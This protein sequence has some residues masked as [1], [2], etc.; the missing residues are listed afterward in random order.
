[1]EECPSENKDQLRKREGEL[2]RE[3]KAGLNKLVAGR[4]SVE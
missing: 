3:H 4:K 2:I 1:M